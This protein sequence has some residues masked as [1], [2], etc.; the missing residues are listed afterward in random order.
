MKVTT[1]SGSVYT[2]DPD[3]LCW[4]RVPGVGA[5]DVRGDAGTLD[6]WYIVLGEPMRLTSYFI[7]G[8]P[9]WRRRVTTTPVVSIDHD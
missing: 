1:E 3:K 4:T 7:P 8:V 5:G 2:I 6:D 9:M